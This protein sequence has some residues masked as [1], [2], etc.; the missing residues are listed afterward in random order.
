[1]WLGN[2]SSVT[3]I[4]ITYQIFNMYFH[5]ILTTI[6][7]VGT[8]IVSILQWG[9]RPGELPTVTYLVVTILSCLVKKSQCIVFHLLCIFKNQVLSSSDFS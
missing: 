3:V 4:I 8:V 6:S 7:K 2:K 5:L 1:M 9:N